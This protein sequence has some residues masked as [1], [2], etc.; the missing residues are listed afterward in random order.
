[1]IKRLEKA[2]I[3]SIINLQT[4][5]DFTDGWNEQMLVSAFDNRFVAFGFYVDNLLKGFIGIDTGLYEYEIESVLVD[6]ECR[7]QGIAKKLLNQAIMLAKENAIESVF[8]EVRKNN[9]P[10][11][12]LYCEAG[13][14]QI[15]ERKGYYP[16]GENAIILKKEI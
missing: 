15:G 2:D 7:R 8:L 4:N 3:S 11:I 5:C 9:L 10:A 12:N 6:K 16:D 1:M 13:F 14:N